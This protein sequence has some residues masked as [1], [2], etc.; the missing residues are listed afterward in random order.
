MS[1]Q[2][3]RPSFCP[4]GREHSC[5]R[6]WP[7]PA[8]PTQAWGTPFPEG[9]GQV[10]VGREGQWSLS[11]GYCLNPCP[12]P[13]AVPSDTQYGPCHRPDT[14]LHVLKEGRHWQGWTSHQ[15]RC[16][17]RS[18]PLDAALPP[19]PRESEGSRCPGKLGAPHLGVPLPAPRLGLP[20][21]HGLTCV[22]AP[23]VGLLNKRLS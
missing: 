1:A 3:S 11:G 19:P 16:H 5:H 21:C 22:P 20:R 15:G 6:L 13:H 17:L 9:E 23:K 4:C 14:Q 18:L 8:P 7:S 10:A 2:P 12:V